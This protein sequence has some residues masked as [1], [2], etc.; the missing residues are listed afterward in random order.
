[1]SGKRIR[2]GTRSPNYLPNTAHQRTGAGGKATTNTETKHK[3]EPNQTGDSKSFIMR[4]KSP[5]NRYRLLTHLPDT[6]NQSRSCCCWN[7]SLCACGA[8]PS[9]GACPSCACPL[10]ITEQRSTSHSQTKRRKR[11]TYFPLTASPILF[12]ANAPPIAPSAP[13]ARPIPPPPPAEWPSHPPAAAPSSEPPRPRSPGCPGCPPGNGP[14][15]P[16]P[17]GGC[18][19]CCG[20]YWPY[21][22][23][24]GG[25]CPYCGWCCGGYCCG[26][27]CGGC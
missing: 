1:M 27:Y 5:L 23:C 7:P 13:V 9:C 4:S 22:C 26:G 10:C 25:P 15:A 17:Y 19:W 24:G 16:P 20:G 12:P 8:S 21:C 3:P 18:C 6:P 11:Q 14:G 2:Q